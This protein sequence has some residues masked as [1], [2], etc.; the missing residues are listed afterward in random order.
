MAS[1]GAPRYLPGRAGLA[2]MA[3]PSLRLVRPRR[4][5]GLQRL[6]AFAH[7]EVF[8]D[9]LPGVGRAANRAELEG[10]LAAQLAEAEARWPDV[11]VDRPRFMTHWAAQLGR[12][13]DVGAAIDQLH[14]PDLYLAFACADRDPSAL[15]AFGTLLSTVAGAVR[16]VDGTPAFVDEI[17]Q[18]L[19]TRVLV[20]EDGR[21]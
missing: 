14:L 2:R 11:S 1:L 9:A 17:L 20:P 18:R 10:R 19:R 13:G 21:S 8:W 3:D 6:T 15:R 12:A 7:A 16:S 4:A 5:R